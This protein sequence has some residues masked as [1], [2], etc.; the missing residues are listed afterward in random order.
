MNLRG[1]DFGHH[2]QSL[3]SHENNV[4]FIVYNFPRPTKKG[5]EKRYLTSNHAL[6]DTKYWHRLGVFTQ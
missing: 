4:S 1:Q 2:L 5:P 3:R 6:M